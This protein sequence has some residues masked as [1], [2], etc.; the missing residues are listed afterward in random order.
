MQREIDALRE[1]KSDLKVQLQ[2]KE[3]NDF[4][5]ATLNAGLQPI[6]GMLQK[7]QSDIDDVKCKQPPTVNVPWPQLRVYN[8]DAAVTAQW[9]AQQYGNRDCGC[10]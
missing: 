4:T 2:L 10:K 5:Q 6:Y 9:V 3:Q 7:L 1:S 8:P